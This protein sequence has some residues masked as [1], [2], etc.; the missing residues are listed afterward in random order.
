MKTTLLLLVGLSSAMSIGQNHFQDSFGSY[1]SGTQLSGQ[2]TW[3]N[4]SSNPGGLGS[5]IVGNGG[6]N[7]NVL[8]S[9]VSYQDFGTSVNSFEIRPNGDGCGTA[10]TP[11]TDG[12]MYVGFVLN[13]S[14][15]QANNNSDFFRVLSG[16]NYNTTFRLYAINTGFG[17]NIGVCKGA[18]G[19]PIGQTNLSY[20]YDQDHLV[21][22][23]YSQFPGA[24]DDLVSVYID[25]VYANGMPASPNATTNTGADQAGSVDRL[26]FRQNWSN[27]MPTGK[28]GL[29]S[30]ARTWD[31]LTFVTLAANEFSMQ[32]AI[33]IDSQN[34]KSGI[35]SIKSGKEIN[36]LLKIYSVNGTLIQ[37]VSTRLSQLTAVNISPLQSSVYIVEITNTETSSKTTQK[38]IVK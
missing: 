5:A 21:I 2:G 29:V 27:G 38:I 18:N 25:P 8:A 26:T 16:G 10:F 22:I 24:G 11:V 32:N 13:L 30:V 23:K 9:S 15:A 3:T 37:E 7:A 33:L 20:S 6:A 1:V 34:A 14:A 19:N 31:D 36:A 4:N 12:D 28:V 35:L 17:F